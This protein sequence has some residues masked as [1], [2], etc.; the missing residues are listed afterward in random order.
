MPTIEQINEAAIRQIGRNPSWKEQ[1]NTIQNSRPASSTAGV[2]LENSP[3]TLI[4]IALRA[5]VAFRGFTYYVDTFDAAAT[6]T[7]NLAGTAVNV[8]TPASVDALLDGMKIAIESSGTLNAL[9]SVVALDAAGDD[10]SV[11]GL[12]TVVLRISGKGNAHY[13]IN[14]SET[15]SGVMIA[16]ADAESCSAKVFLLAGGVA[17]NSVEVVPSV[18]ALA[19]GE[20]LAI[21]DSNFFKRYKT[22]GLKRAFVY[23]FTLAGTS[24]VGVTFRNPDVHIGPAVDE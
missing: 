7:L 22:A 8:A 9:V 17:S 14:R 20:T 24:D 5:D 15:G 2:Y 21:T 4:M 6:Y 19:D 3:A 12:D 13:S 18:W 11:S 23:V 16:K 1:D 10:V